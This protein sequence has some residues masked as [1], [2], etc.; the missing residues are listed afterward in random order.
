ME[1]SD[2]EIGEKTIPVVPINIKRLCVCL[3]RVLK[4]DQAYAMD[5]PRTQGRKKH[6]H[7]KWRALSAA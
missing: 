4:C 6:R 5:T 3:S 1:S 7:H 2:G